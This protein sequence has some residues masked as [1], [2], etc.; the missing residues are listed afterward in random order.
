MA[1]RPRKKPVKKMRGGGL[2]KM[3]A[4]KMRKG[5]VVKKKKK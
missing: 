5:G 2:A 3:P 4:K 1:M